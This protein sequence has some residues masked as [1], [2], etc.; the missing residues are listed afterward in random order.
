MI[1]GEKV[2]E[3]NSSLYRRIESGEANYVYVPKLE[4]NNL[5]K[6]IIFHEV[7]EVTGIRTG[8]GCTR[9]LLASHTTRHGN[10][11]ACMTALKIR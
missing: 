5:I 7:H 1:E 4:L 2:V 9:R 11:S 8:N 10:G 3:V 6:V